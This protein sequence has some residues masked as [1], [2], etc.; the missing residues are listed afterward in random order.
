MWTA[1][2]ILA[3]VVAGGFLLA[4]GIAKLASPM[5]WR[6]VW[7]AA[8]RLL[9]RPLVRPTALL[10]PTV[11]ITSGAALLAGAFG[12]G[13]L[14]AAAGL[15][16]ALTLAVVAALL[17]H[18]EISCGC[19]GRLAARVSGRAVTRNLALIVALALLAWHGRLTPIAV[20]ALPWPA[21]VA[22]L[23]GTALAVHGGYA[24]A[25]ARQRRTFLAAISGRASGG[26][27][28]AE[29]SDAP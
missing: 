14:V 16:A 5:T 1:L 18:L 10:L 26:L 9:P 4:A 29:G 12:A 3:R 21:Q 25:R 23:A 11:E 27:T 2:E 24:A 8:Y 15:L 13:S 7:L 19:T 28:V 17:R 6:Q 22:A 20:S